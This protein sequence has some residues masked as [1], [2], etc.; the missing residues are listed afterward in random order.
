MSGLAWNQKE[1]WCA[2]IASMD[3]VA[4]IK[5]VPY[6]EYCFCDATGKHIRI[7]GACVIS[8]DNDEKLW[9]HKAVPALKDY[10]PDPASKNYVVIKMTPDNVRVTCPDFTY[11]KVEI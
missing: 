11:E 7:A 1:L 6:A 5:K 4:Q 2:T 10:I 9:L 3:K 8:T